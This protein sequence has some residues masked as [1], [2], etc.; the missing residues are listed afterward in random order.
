MSN[1]S[2]PHGLQHARLPCPSLSP[3]ACSNSCPSSQWCHP[4]IS[5]SVTPF[6]SCP[7]S[8]PASG[9]FPVSPL[10]TSGDQT[11]E[12]STL[13]SVIPIINWGWFPLR[14]TGLIFA[15]QGTLKSLLQHHSSK[16][17]VLWHSLHNGQAI[18]ILS[19]L[20]VFLCFCIFSFLWLS[21][22]FGTWGR[23]RELN[24]PTNKRQVEDTVGFRG[25]C[26]QGP[27]GPVQLPATP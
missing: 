3:G 9:S 23:P 13:A 14:L 22:F 6:S 12:A 11:T 15:V 26:P 4:A 2:Q 18:I 25:V 5:S 16:A 7:Q 27:W 24:L 8:F 17:S 21:L 19:C 20:T 10:F 1:S